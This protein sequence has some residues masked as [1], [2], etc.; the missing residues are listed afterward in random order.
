VE[1]RIFTN[2]INIATMKKVLMY[3]EVI[4]VAKSVI[5]YPELA[6]CQWRCAYEVLNKTTFV[7]FDHY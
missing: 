2:E 6:V 7:Q 4:V 5:E 1:I 3:I